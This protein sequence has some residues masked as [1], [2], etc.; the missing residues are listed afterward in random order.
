MGGMVRG[1][2]IPELAL[3][4]ENTVAWAVN[5]REENS[6][7]W[8]WTCCAR[9]CWRLLRGLEACPRP[10]LSVSPAL[11]LSASPGLFQGVRVACPIG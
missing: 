6:R 7:W 9:P 11:G 2:P 3:N 4:P 5:L 1:T 10:F 8:R